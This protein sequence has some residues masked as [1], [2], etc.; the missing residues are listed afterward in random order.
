MSTPLHDAF[1]QKMVEVYER[2]KTECHYNAVRFHQMVQEYGGLAAAKKLL[3]SSH[4]P[5]G[6]TR[7]WELKRLDISM[8]ATV[9]QEPWCGLFTSDE[10][11]VAKK[12][13]E[14]LGYLNA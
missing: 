3:A 6:L 10:L 2:A 8:E 14:E 9:L 12:R 7:L 4:Y 5:E 13:L 11:A 1:H